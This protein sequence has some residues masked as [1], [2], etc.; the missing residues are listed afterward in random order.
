MAPEPIAQYQIKQRVCFI[1]LLKDLKLGVFYENCYEI[2]N[3][4]NLPTISK[5]LEKNYHKIL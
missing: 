5:K 3:I 2:Y 1:R 4:E